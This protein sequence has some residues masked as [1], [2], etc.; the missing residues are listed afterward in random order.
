MLVGLRDGRTVVRQGRLLPVE[1]P[2]V[3]VIQSQVYQVELMCA[4][5]ATSLVLE[6]E[7]DLGASLD[8][9]FSRLQE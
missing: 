4:G 1:G 9:G 2:I 6:E 3:S 8:W 5:H 7:I